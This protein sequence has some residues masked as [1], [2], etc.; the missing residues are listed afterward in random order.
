MSDLLFIII[1][2]KKLVYN[3]KKNFGY[4]INYVHFIYNLIN[5]FHWFFFNNND[6]SIVK[7]SII[8]EKKN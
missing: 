4:I 6:I 5:F 8:I 2:Q 7:L 3:L 1:P